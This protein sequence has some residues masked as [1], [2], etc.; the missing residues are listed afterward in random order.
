M[1]IYSVQGP[2]GRIYDIEGPKGASDAQVISALQDYLE[3]QPPPAKPKTGIGAAIGQ[4]VEQ[5]ISSGRTAYGALTGS[6]EEAA[7]AGLARGEDIGKRYEDQVSL[8][9]VKDVYAARG[10]LPAAGE[11]I[12]QIPAAIAQQAP[13]LASMAGSA[14]LGDGAWWCAS[15]ALARRSEEGGAVLH[16][17]YVDLL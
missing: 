9:K 16:C 3:S 12:S 7:Q 4:G 13:N 15:S 10:I 5:L 11:A 6:P 14:R 8:Q 17:D 2:D 1:P